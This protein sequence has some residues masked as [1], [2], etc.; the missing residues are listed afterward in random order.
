MKTIDF[1]KACIGL[2]TVFHLIACGSSSSKSPQFLPGSVL[3]VTGKY[4]DEAGNGFSDQQLL[5]QNLRKFGYI[6][7][8]GVAIESFARLLAFPFFAF[9]DVI[10]EGDSLSVDRSK[11]LQSPNYN[12]KRVR[13]D[14]SGS[15]TF[16]LRVEDLLRDAEGGINISIV[17]EK[18]S[19]TLFGKFSFVVKNIGTDLGTLNL[20]TLGGIGM[21]EDAVL[22]TATFSWSAPQTAVSR[23]VLRFGDPTSGAVIWTQVV[24]GSLTTLTLPRSLFLN[25]KVRLGIEAF[26]TFEAEKKTSCL[27]AP[28][29][30][31]LTSP[32]SSL[33]SGG[34]VNASN[35]KFKI[36]SLTNAKFSD[37][38]FFEAF[39]S[40]EF[41][42]DLGEQKAI[43]KLRLYNLQLQSSG[44]LSVSGSLDGSTYTAIDQFEEARFM[45]LSLTNP[46]SLRFLK[47]SFSS[48]LVDLQ[49]LALY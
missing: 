6:D 40:R 29:D 23:Y 48:R 45:N 31:H 12:L 37:N 18:S 43:S 24:D 46:T 33:A 13:T 49:E 36:N 39:D 9:Y 17:N 4:L 44:S 15:F 38:P 2:V 25:Q 19:S 20:C 10:F 21:A 1:L 14:G 7:E 16:N 28:K 5:F 42:L 27:S 30:F 8:T 3:T 41:V 34:I 22:D 35:V 26:Y 11:Y 47:F 32:L